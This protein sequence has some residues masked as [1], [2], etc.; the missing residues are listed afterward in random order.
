MRLEFL[1][2]RGSTP[3]SGQGYAMFGGATACVRV[4]SGN[5]EIY[6][7][8]GT[9]IVS[10]RPEKDTNISV[11]FSHM[12]LDHIEGL[13][14]FSALGQKG[15]SI[16]LYGKRREG[17]S[18]AD[19]LDSI[20]TPPFW[21]VGLSDYPADITVSD[22]PRT[23]TI[24]NVK[25]TH[26]ESDHPGGSTIYRLDEGNSSFVYATD[27]EHGKHTKDLI[28]FSKGASLIAYDGQY[29]ED[30][31]DDYRGF[32]HSTAS[33]G[34]DIAWRAGAKKVCIIHHSPAHND[35]ALL[36]MERAAGIHFVRCGEST[37][38]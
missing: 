6:L 3:I 19:I 18:V 27:F 8:A 34:K 36:K 11:L 22:L 7:D 5:E 15:R 20:F 17:A 10:A 29:D 21:P 30:E 14:F 38:V 32:G 37:T 12:H 1:G 31:Y 24:G 23:L 13:P 2:T 9:G 16:R 33:V 35:E 28:E 4:I 26:M 25:I